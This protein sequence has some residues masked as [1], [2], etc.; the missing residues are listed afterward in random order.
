MEQGTFARRGLFAAVIGMGILIILGVIAL[1]AVIIH[2]MSHP[3]LPVAA[4]AG[5][6]LS[7]TAATIPSQTFLLH[8]P[9]GT[10]IEQI[11]WSNGPIMAIRLSGGGPDRIV[12]WDTGAGRSVGEINLAQ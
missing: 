9:A 10:R 4:P 1:V 5:I 8:E 2:R 7:A 6:S 11:V 12:L 3:R